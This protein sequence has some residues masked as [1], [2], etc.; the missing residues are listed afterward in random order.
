[1]AT[2]SG[3]LAWRIPWTEEPGGL[4]SM[5]SQSVRH[6]WATSLT[7]SLTQVLGKVLLHQK[8]KEGK[9]LGR[10]G[11]EERTGRFICRPW[12]LG[13]S[14]KAGFYGEDGQRIRVCRETSRLTQEKKGKGKTRIRV[15]GMRS[16]LILGHESH[17]ESTLRDIMC[18]KLCP[19]SWLFA[20]PRTVAHQA[21]LCM[22]LRNWTLVSY[23][24]CIGRRVLYH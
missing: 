19:S 15:K 24:C 3:I 17:A 6:D 2:H 22:R 5:G 7:H 16:L 8:W 18:A 9:A 10:D 1:M 14:A 12:A 11:G 4:Q 20:T 13:V 21:P 23:V